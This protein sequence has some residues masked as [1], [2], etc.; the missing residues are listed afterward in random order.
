MILSKILSNNLK[1]A[2][3]NIYFQTIRKIL[4]EQLLILQENMIFR[5]LIKHF[6]MIKL[7]IILLK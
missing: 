5:F 4:T 1:K 3:I 6:R 2:V 7:S